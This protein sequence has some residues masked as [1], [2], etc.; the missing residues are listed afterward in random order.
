M[1]AT[2]V[3]EFGGP[4]VVELEEV[5]RAASC[6]RAGPASDPRRWRA[7]RR[8]AVPKD[9]LAGHSSQVEGHQQRTVISAANLIRIKTHQF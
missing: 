3:R 7:N 2:L 5:P 1:K 8:L 9:K 4:G 6:G